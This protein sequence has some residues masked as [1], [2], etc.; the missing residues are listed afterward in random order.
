MLEELNN[1]KTN[2][3]RE[4]LDYISVKPII[5]MKH[6]LGLGLEE[7]KELHKPIRHKFRRR[8]VFVFNADDIWSADLKDMQQLSRQNKGYKYLL[9][10]IDLFSKYVYSIPLKS[11]SSHEITTAFEKLFDSSD[12]KPQK[13]WTD[14][15]SE[16][17]NN[18]FKQF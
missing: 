15:G 8:R 4:K 9:N 17:T 5:W 2:G 16:F 11:K 7:A 18:N 13:L 12:R 1:I 6:K 14:Q 10:I 3:F